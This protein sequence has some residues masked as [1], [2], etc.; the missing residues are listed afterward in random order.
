MMVLIILRF[1]VLLYHIAG[2]PGWLESQA[3]TSNEHFLKII[4]FWSCSRFVVNSVIDRLMATV[5]I[6]VIQRHQIDPLHDTMMFPRPEIT[7]E[8]HQLAVRFI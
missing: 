7:H 2:D 4:V 1:A 8:G 5:R 6:G 3:S